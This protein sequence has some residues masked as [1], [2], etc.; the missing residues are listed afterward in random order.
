MVKSLC[1][2]AALI[3]SVAFLVGCDGGGGGDSPVVPP[4]GADVD[5]IWDGL[6]VVTG[7]TQAPVGFAFGL[8]FTLTQVDSQ[9][10]GTAVTEGGLVSDVM[11]TVNGQ[12]F[13]FTLRFG[14]RL[15]CP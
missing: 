12:A 5:G 6:A 3:M 4:P 9:V 7:G 1:W 10:T 11:G 13:T 8:L 14:F 2:A 15:L